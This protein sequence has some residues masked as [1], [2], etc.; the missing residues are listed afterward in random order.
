M[1]ADGAP[2][3]TS[4]ELVL[5]SNINKYGTESVMGRALGHNEILSMNTAQVIVSAYNERFKATDW[6]KWAQDNPAQSR[7]VNEAMKLAEEYGWS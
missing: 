7:L 5:L 3:E 4:P 6:V 2:I 1:V